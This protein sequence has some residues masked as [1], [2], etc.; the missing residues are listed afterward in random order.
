MNAL[1]GAA[2]RKHDKFCRQTFIGG[3][4][5][6][7]DKYTLKPNPDYYAAKLFGTLM[8]KRV[9]E[10]RISSS[11]AAD[12]DEEAV[13]V[14]GYAHCNPTGGVTLLLLNHGDVS[15]SVLSLSAFPGLGVAPLPPAPRE[16][17]VLTGVSVET[18]FDELH[19]NFVALNGVPLEVGG[20]GAL[21]G[22]GPK[23]VEEGG[24]VMPATS[25]GFFVFTEWEAS[26]CK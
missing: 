15:A 5:E 1:G 14:N 23:L 7:V 11:S 10:V 21:P 4:Y 12:G 22:L 17:Y 9:L 6:L 8:G 19:S 3:N 24:I 18:A 2:F 13:A 26:A 25:Y 20:D 16:E